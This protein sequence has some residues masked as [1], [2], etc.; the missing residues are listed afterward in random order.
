MLDF[1]FLHQKVPVLEARSASESFR[2]HA[3]PAERNGSIPRGATAR[4][5][6]FLGAVKEMP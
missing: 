3:T 4:M 1:V 2:L 6:I 5:A